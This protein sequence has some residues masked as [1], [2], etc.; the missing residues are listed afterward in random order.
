[1]SV[2][3]VEI[4]TDTYPCS[5][6]PVQPFDKELLVISEST[7][8]TSALRSEYSQVASCDDFIA[9]QGKRFFLRTNSELYR[10][11]VAGTLN[12]NYQLTICSDRH[13]IYE[14]MLKTIRTYNPTHIA[15][16]PKPIEPIQPPPRPALVS[17]SKPQPRSYEVSEEVFIKLCN[18]YTN[19]VLSSPLKRATT[20]TGAISQITD[21]LNGNYVKSVPYVANKEKVAKMIF[22]AFVLARF[23]EVQG[24]KILY[25]DHSFR[26]RPFP[27]TTALYQSVHDAVDTPVA[28]LTPKPIKITISGNDGG[29]VKASNIYLNSYLCSTRL[30]KFNA[31]EVMQSL[32]KIVRDLSI[33]SA[34]IDDLSEVIFTSFCAANYYT[35]KKEDLSVIYNTSLCRCKS[36][37]A[38][39]VPSPVFYSLIE[40][41]L[42][43]TRQEPPIPS[44]PPK[45]PVIQQEEEPET[46]LPLHITNIIEKILLSKYLATPA[47]VMNTL[48]QA[49]LSYEK[50]NKIVFDVNEVEEIVE[51]IKEFLNEAG[52]STE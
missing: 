1:M 38:A 40:K 27:L 12:S 51:T 43:T 9:K 10:G 34:L 16:V 6:P 7:V 4:L 36:L 5:L 26:N 29:Y 15:A 41:V 35:V 20:V 37:T 23:I 13:D 21:V 47:Q 25:N 45:S 28:V 52:Y 32:K 18:V 3:L 30:R 2:L 50:E 39:N 11:I 19:N 46:G 49:F 33:P 44:M 17:Q 14:N 31:R 24:E 48:Q 42:V 22:E 8:L